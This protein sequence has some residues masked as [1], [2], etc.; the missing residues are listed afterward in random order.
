MLVSDSRLSE[1]KKKAVV[2]LISN[3]EALKNAQTLYDD[4]D[5][6][7]IIQ[8]NITKLP[9]HIRELYGQLNSTLSTLL[10]TEKIWETYFPTQ[11]DLSLIEFQKLNLAE[12]EK[13]FLLQEESYNN[14]L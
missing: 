13:P 14:L 3:E 6:N 9:T 10:K 8:T 11:S 2:N 12:S 7:K 1:D 4:P 5:L